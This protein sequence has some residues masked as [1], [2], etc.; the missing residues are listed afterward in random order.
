[1]ESTMM[2]STSPHTALLL[3]GA[4]RGLGLAIAK[5]YLDHG[6]EVV[7][8]VRSA[9]RT[10]LHDLQDK[11]AGRLEIEHIDI[12]IPEQIVKLHNRLASRV[13]DLLFV[14]AGVTNNADETIADV[15]IEEF[16]RLMVTNALS[17]MRVIEGLRDL[18]APDGTI[19]VMSPGQGS[20][21]N[22]ERGGF[23][24]YRGTKAALN[25]F[26]R[27][28][29]ARNH[30]DPRTLLLMAPGC[31]QT[32]LGGPNARLTIDE[33]IP[34]LVKVIDAQHGHGGLQFLDYR[35]ETVKW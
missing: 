12:T 6:S 8:T 2:T 25:M 15:S 29:A 5:E 11:S 10:E 32:R 16:T 19:A 28:Y 26:M 20:I 3:I 35:G 24:V 1:M 9:S 13:F 4:S 31:V 34:N 21:A 33:S 23:E 17:P 18:A 7:A 14:N 30:D 22:N 27:S